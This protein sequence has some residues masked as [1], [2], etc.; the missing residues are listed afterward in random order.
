MTIDEAIKHAERVAEANKSAN[1]ME[2][3]E[4]HL[5]LVKWLKELQEY[6]DINL[7]PAEIKALKEEN[8]AFRDRYNSIAALS[9]TLLY[10][11]VK[12]GIVD[13]KAVEKLLESFDLAFLCKM[14]EE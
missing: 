13:K 7:T 3:A 11:A 9:I 1:C 8:T 10:E 4:E 2:C 14:L 5:Q 6:K 12:Q